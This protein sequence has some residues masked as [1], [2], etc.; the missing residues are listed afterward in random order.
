MCP[1]P[2]FSFSGSKTLSHSFSTCRWQ[3]R[4]WRHPLRSREPGAAASSSRSSRARASPALQPVATRA[5]LSRRWAAPWAP[6]CASTTVTYD[7]TPTTCRCWGRSGCSAP[8][9]C[10]RRLSLRHLEAIKS[11][12][13]G[14]SQNL[15]I[16]LIY[17]Y[18]SSLSRYCQY[19]NTS[20]IMPKVLLLWRRTNSWE[21]TCLKGKFH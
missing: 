16:K 9:W 18:K 20:Y 13:A 12:F 8:P 2:I 15:L 19:S 14:T 11:S 3:S 5:Q 6:R 1:R 21:H 10:R 7:A 17:V 4:P